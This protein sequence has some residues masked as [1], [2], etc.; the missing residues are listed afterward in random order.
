MGHYKIEQWE[1]EFTRE[2][3]YVTFVWSPG[4]LFGGRW[5]EI[6]RASTKDGAEA[7]IREHERPAEGPWFYPADAI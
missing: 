5:E 7:E 6:D 1:N 4:W 2:P 3:F